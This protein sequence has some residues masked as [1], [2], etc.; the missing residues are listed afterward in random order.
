MN[1]Y[2]QSGQIFEHCC[3][4]YHL[5]HRVPATAEQLM[6]SRFSAYC[7]GSATSI[8]YLAESYHFLSQPS[9]PSHEIT[10]FAKAAHFIGLKIIN[11]SAPS[12]LPTELRKTLLPHGSLTSLG[13]AT[14]HF[15]VKFMMD[16][17]LQML[18]EISR[19]IA[20]EGRWSYLDGTLF[21]HPQQKLSRNDSCPC[22]SGKKYKNCRP[23]LSAG[24]KK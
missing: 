21:D 23:H 5:G 13:F 3:Q 2:C 1:C 12:E 19:F 20:T 8:R 9:N 22:G 15:Q 10:A 4:P 7:E 6:R 24:Q 14:V 17:R 11:S 18:E 16:D